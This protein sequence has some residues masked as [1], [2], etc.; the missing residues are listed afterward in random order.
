MIDVYKDKNG[1]EYSN[2]SILLGI[3]HH[4]KFESKEASLIKELTAT[5][6][7]PGL[8][9]R[10]AIGWDIKAA[11]NW[12]HKHSGSSTQHACATYV[13]SAIDVGFKTNPN[14]SNSYTANHGFYI[15]G[16]KQIKGRP[17]WAWKYISYLPTIGF[18]FLEKVSR[19]GASSFNAEPGDI[20]VYQKAGNPNVPGHICMWTG[21]RWTSDFKQNNMIVYNRTQ[22]AY[23]FRFK[24]VYNS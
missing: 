17:T 22:E 10:N 11:C 16:G 21:E 14:G 7:D 8:F 2:E 20:A 6:L 13:R 12:I 19:T 24:Y 9:K 15:D 23:I 4:S 1:V 3:L 18:E 5:D